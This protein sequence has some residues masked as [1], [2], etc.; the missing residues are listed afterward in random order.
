MHARNT[1]IICLLSLRLITA[2]AGVVVSVIP[3]EVFES[4]AGEGGPG[5]SGPSG[6]A[7]GR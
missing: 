2:S 6:L 1:T 4:K 7:R 5:G 3:E